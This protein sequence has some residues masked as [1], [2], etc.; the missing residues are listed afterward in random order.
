MDVF[1]CIYCKGPCKIVKENNK[2]YLDCKNCGKKEITKLGLS[3]LEA[4]REK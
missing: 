2:D 1:K 3:R 4:R